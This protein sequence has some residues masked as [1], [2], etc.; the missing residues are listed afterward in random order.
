MRLRHW[1]PNTEVPCLKPLGFS[2][3]DS[4][5]HPSKIG[6]MSTRNFRELSDKRQ[7]TSSKWLLNPI[8]KKGPRSFF[9]FLNYL[10]ISL[11]SVVSKDF[12]KL[13][14]NRSVNN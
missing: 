5:F 12:E 10:P 14:N 1:I 8:H 7:T 4:A 2:K 3:M 6:K 11:L 9:S 13:V